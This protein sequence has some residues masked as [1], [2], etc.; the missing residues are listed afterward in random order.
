MTGRFIKPEELRQWWASIRP[1]LDYL[2]TKTPEEWIPEDVYSDCLNNRALAFAWMD[3]QEVKGY[4]IVQ[5]M[6]IYLHVWAAWSLENKE[7]IVIEALKFVKEIARQGNAKY[8][9]FSSHRRGWDKRAAELGFKPRQW[10]CE[11]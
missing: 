2:Q 8:L 11:V 3:G 6:G 5:P 7:E 10:I 1:G 4:F 9:T